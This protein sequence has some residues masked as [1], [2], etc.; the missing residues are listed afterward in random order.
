MLS[1]LKTALSNDRGESIIAVIAGTIVFVAAVAGF[2][3]LATNFLA[4]STLAQSNSEVT[5]EIERQLQDFEQTAWGNLSVESKK[6]TSFK[7]GNTSYP[8]TREVVFDG[9]KTSYELRIASPRA[10]TPGKPFT[11]CT[12]A[13]TKKQDGCLSLSASVAATA[14]D[15]LPKSVDGITINSLYV[16]GDTIPNG[17]TNPGFE[18][19]TA[20]YTAEPAGAL[21]IVSQKAPT[22]SGTKAAQLT[23]AGSALTTAF[24]PVNSSDRMQFQGYVRPTG[25]NGSIELSLLQK[26][27]AGTVKESPLAI[28]ASSAMSWQ[29]V[30]TTIDLSG[31][32][33]SAAVK[34]TLKNGSATNNKWLIDD[35]VLGAKAPN[36]TPAGDFEER[37]TKWSLD[38]GAEIAEGAGYD[39]FD[40]KA[41]TL[42]AE[43]GGAA[44]LND[45]I[46]A[47][48]LG[49]SFTIILNAKADSNYAGSLTA[50]IT[51][52][53]SST[54]TWKIPGGSLSSEWQ[55]QTTTI[56]PAGPLGIKTLA[57]AA[58]PS[59]DSTGSISLD[60]ITVYSVDDA[61]PATGTYITLATISKSAFPKGTQLRLSF[62]SE[63]KGLSSSQRV[64]VYCTTSASERPFMYTPLTVQP[65]GD[66]NWYW[67]RIQVP[68]FSI[69]TCPNPNIRVYSTS[70]TLLN[71]EKI[72]TLTI[73]RVLSGVNTGSH[74]G[75]N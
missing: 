54:A 52:S 59:A 49:S 74:T 15:M 66:E 56:T 65:N 24:Y 18:K 60:D 13:L 51:Y 34:A 28:R 72:G 26:N 27:A 73:L 41:L 64:G 37:T 29:K 30:I 75:D 12:D 2:V 19:G 35:L 33:V 23:G 62:Q 10:T 50:T 68:D 36:R 21:A 67:G 71:P 42:K 31:G 47:T 16:S 17:L 4:A 43:T 45:A 7:I 14:E 58:T 46:S 11:T 63:E 48:H 57:F 38:P 70:G 6:T 40:G 32:T 8:I 39:E 20:G 53:D 5:S 55:P 61:I 9:A 3:S 1:R 69:L 22:S 25:T 44:T